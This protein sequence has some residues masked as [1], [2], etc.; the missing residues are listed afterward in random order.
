[1]GIEEED[2]PVPH[3]ANQMV[4]IEL[5][6][7]FRDLTIHIQEEQSTLGGVVI[8]WPDRQTVSAT[9]HPCQ[10]RDSQLELRGNTWR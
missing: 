6:D 3:L 4:L 8:A 10:V 5:E 1:M 7:S 2:K 9:D